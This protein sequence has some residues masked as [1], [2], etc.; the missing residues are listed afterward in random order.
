M[1]LFFIIDENQQNIKKIILTYLDFI[2]FFEE[3][4]ELME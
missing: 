4:S 2:S 3:V 1:G